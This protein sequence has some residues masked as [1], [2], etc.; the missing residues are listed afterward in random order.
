MALRE[1]IVVPV[2]N[3]L[4]LPA[5]QCVPLLRT[6]VLVSGAAVMAQEMCASRLIQ[7]FFG[8][9]LLIW[10]NLIGLIMIYL[11][12]GYFFGGKLADRYPLPNLLYSLTGL[13]ALGFGLTPLLSNT[14][15]TG[16]SIAS[17]N[18]SGGLFI[19]SLVSILLL[20]SLPL[21]LL[22]CVTPF[23][24]RLQVLE[25]SSAGKTAGGISSLSTLGSIFGT[26][27]SV[28]YLLPN[29]GVS[30]TL[31][32]F[33]LALALVSALGWFLNRRSRTTSEPVALDLKTMPINTPSLNA[34]ATHNRHISQHGLLYG[35]VLVCG[36]A[37]MATEMCASRLIQPYFGDSLL[38]WA[39][40]IGFI[41]I[42]LAIGYYLG[43]R[44]ADR[45]PNPAFLYQLIGWAAFTMG[46]IPV[47]SDP[48]LGLAKIGFD[49]VDGGLF[50]GSLVGIV[51][52]FSVPLLLLGCV[53]PFAVRLLILEQA[54]AGKTAGTISSLSTLG[55]IAGTFGPVLVSIPAV[56]T[57]STLYIF[58]LG[59]LLASLLGLYLTQKHA[60]HRLV[61]YVSMLVLV[62]ALAFGL[63]TRTIKPTNDGILLY[64]KESAINY[65][66]VVQ[67]G[68]NTLLVL[69]E[70]HA[71]HSIYNPKQVLTGGYWDYYML[72]PFF[73]KNAT[74]NQVKNVLMIGLAAGTVPHILSSAYGN[75]LKID[76][77]EIDPEI[78]K[79]GAE[80][81]HTNEQTNLTPIAEDGRYY[82]VTSTKKYDLVGVD[83][84]HQ[85]YIPFYL[86][87]REF[88]QQVRDH[89]TTQGV[90]AINVGS[91]A[92]ANG[93]RDYRLVNTIASTMRTV[94]P[95]V[96][97]ADV[98]GTF[99]SVVVATNQASDSQA[100]VSNLA[101]TA[102]SSQMIQQIGQNVLQKGN[103]REWTQTAPIFTDD[104]APVEQLIDQI[105]LDYVVG[106]GK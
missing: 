53:T 47:L 31:Y 80:Y 4:A 88:F 70:G 23:A 34:P 24:V 87:T 10:A 35:L 48:I 12:L 103:L 89:L 77:V 32:L 30:I 27:G 42:Y 99:N 44:L 21:I 92:A 58:A 33:A 38:I 2:S 83:A 13:A 78:I 75:Q 9:S 84:F 85:P 43:G 81:F 61:V 93:E 36:I 7:P 49:K 17:A 26:F 62:L 15:L 94:F 90:A 5:K 41:M 97:I 63:V 98:P 76:G 51:L 56:G 11:S 104:H 100:L 72:A 102:V 52:L 57:R 60:W 28:L 82:L 79:V 96:F 73:A 86:T 19:G 14:V 106:G 20:F 64:E 105:I 74:Q 69:N 95:T 39:N 101:G 71:I 54:N 46:L 40:L 3:S 29:F 45:Y 25:R 68:D 50:Y 91:P 66:Q 18:L 55:S 8:N 22:G 59:L 1:K 37:V 6:L 67:S 65:I 16:V